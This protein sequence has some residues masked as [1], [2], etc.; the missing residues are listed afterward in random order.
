MAR[1]HVIKNAQ[2]GAVSQVPFTPEE[3]TAADAAAAFVPVPAVI[4]RRQFFQQLAVMNVITKQEAK[5]AA[6]GAIPSTM[7]TIID[8]LPTEDD[9][10]AAEMLVTGAGEFRRDH[11]LVA[12]FAGAMEWSSEQVD[13]LFR[14]ASLL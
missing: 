2:T 7:Q 10:F 4:S 3:E 14:A 5:T 1:V 11:P 9:R 13:D 6:T 8:A 12:F